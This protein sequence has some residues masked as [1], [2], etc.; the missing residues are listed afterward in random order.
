MIQK[1]TNYL[2]QTYQICTEV[3]ENGIV[4]ARNERW[5]DYLSMS[6]QPDT[7]K[8]ALDAF[9]D[10]TSINFD[11]VILSEKVDGHCTTIFLVYDCFHAEN[12]E[13]GEKVVQPIFAAVKV[14]V[15]LRLS[16]N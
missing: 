3:F 4:I 5:E 11:P 12:R 8:L 9:V 13:T 16:L 10:A 6:L 15:N 1:L 7:K 14:T 2:M